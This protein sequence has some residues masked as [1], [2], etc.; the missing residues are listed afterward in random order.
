M[1]IEAGIAAGPSAAGSGRSARRVV[2]NAGCFVCG[3]ENPTGLHL[4]FRCSPVE[5]AADWTPTRASAGF[6]DIVHGGIIATVLDEAMSKAIMA[7]HCEAMTAEIRV[8]FRRPLLPGGAVQVRGWV[9]E[10]R[11]R[12]ILAEAALTAAGGEEH[13][14]AWATFLILPSAGTA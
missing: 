6:Q 1:T 9:I 11:K 3:A 4:R 13:A 7:R 12:R 5:A 14:H 8:R 2:S 10:K